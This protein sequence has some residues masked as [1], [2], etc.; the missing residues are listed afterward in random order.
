M[1]PIFLGMNAYEIAYSL[2][3]IALLGGLLLWKKR[4]V[5]T[6]SL[7]VP[8]MSHLYHLLF[9]EGERD[10]WWD[11]YE[12]AVFAEVVI[13]RGIT[14][15]LF[16]IWRAVLRGR[17]RARG[18]SAV[19]R[20]RTRLR[21]TRAGFRRAAPADGEVARR[22]STVCPFRAFSALHRA[23]PL[24]PPCSD[25]MALR[26]ALCRKW[27]PFRVAVASAEIRIVRETLNVRP[28]MLREC[29]LIRAPVA[30]WVVYESLEVLAVQS[31]VSKSPHTTE[32]RRE[33]IG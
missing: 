14:T 18:D 7:W 1:D 23:W 31:G 3:C 26:V 9:G 21:R 28:E 17:S 16:E 4:F 2:A 22:I 19:R 33:V 13:L 6:V 20:R 24:R 10:V 25:D 5:L 15:I 11:S 32:H 30:V 12:I 27:S 8:T 29:A